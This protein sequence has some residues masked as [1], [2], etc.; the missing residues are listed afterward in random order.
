MENYVKFYNANDWSSGHNLSEA[1]KIIN[2]FDKENPPTNINQII[3]LYNIKLFFDHDIKLIAWDEKIVDKYKNIVRTFPSVIGKFF[4]QINNDNIIDLFQQTERYYHTD[5]WVLIEYYRVHSRLT[6]EVFSNLL[7]ECGNILSHILSCGK[8]VEAFNEQIAAEL[9]NN[10]GY[11]ELIFNHYIVKHTHNTQKL[12]IPSKLTAKDQKYILKNYIEWENANPNYLNLISTL[13]KSEDFYTDD[14]IR[15]QAKRKYIEY[16]KNNKRVNGMSWFQEV[17]ISFSDTP[18]EYVELSHRIEENKTIIQ[19]VYNNDWLIENLDYATLLN[20]FIYLFNYTDLQFRCQFLSNPSKLGVLEGMLGLSGKTEYKTGMAYQ[21]SNM[22]SSVQMVAYISELKKH[23]IELESIFKWFFEE[24]LKDEFSISGFKY[25]I[26]STAASYLEKILI[27]ITQLDAVVKQ[28]KLF[29]EDGFIDREL[30]E[31]SSLPDKLSSAPSLISD[32]YVY[33]NDPKIEQMINLIFSDQSI[34]LHATDNDSKNYDSFYELLS[35]ENIT[36][37]DLL[38]F[39]HTALQWLIEQGIIFEDDKY[40]LKLNVDKVVILNNL[41]SNG[42][43][44]YTY[45]RDLS[46]DIIDTWIKEGLLIKES[47]LFSRQEQEYLDYML[48]VQKFS[49]GPE[50]RNKYAHGVFSLNEAEHQ[51]DYVE[52]LK[53]MVLIIIKINEEFC[54]K[55]PR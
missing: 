35:H 27:L 38:E 7:S 6:P 33:S 30:F 13:K 17:N 18:K 3:E 50:L 43:L 48:N 34:L 16:W 10:V 5:F 51:R 32:K 4:S 45:F 36:K 55:Y 31:F 21:T 11:A 39:T 28:F 26:P 8:I 24:Y 37:T 25:T 9:R 47:S 42:V 53:I 40:Y 29:I 44:S 15:L 52:L 19:Y 41:H 2:D 14:R 46:K 23:S 49:N 22:I 1:E 54:I 20:N 12:Y